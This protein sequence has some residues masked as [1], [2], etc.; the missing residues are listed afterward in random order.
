L[1]EQLKELTDRLVAAPQLD[2]SGSWIASKVTRPSLD[3][4]GSWVQGQITQ[5]IT[6]EGDSPQT[7]D[8]R[9]KERTF[10]PFA[11]YSTISSTTTSAIPSP[12]MST[13][14]LADISTPPYRTG[15]A[16]ALRPSSSNHVP[17][18]RASSAMD[19]V[20]RKASPVPRVSSAS[21]TSASFTDVQPTR[22][23]STSVLSNEATP[24]AHNI[25]PS[26]N[27]TNLDTQMESARGEASASPLTGAW[28]GASESGAPTPTASQFVPLGHAVPAS[29]DGFISLM[30]DP[31]FSMTPTAT[32]PSAIDRSSS[33]ESNEED[34]DDLGLGNSMKRKKHEANGHVGDGE[35]EIEAG[36]HD[37]T[38]SQ[39]P[40]KPAEK[41]AAS[42][43]WLSR[44]LG[45]NSNA[46]VKA[47]LGEQTS[48]Y[49]DKDLKRWVNKNAKPEDPKPSA[50]PPPPRAQT[51]SPGTASARLPTGPS[52]GPP[53]P[54]RP[55]T[56]IDLTDSPPRKPP[57]RVRSNL[58]PP[59]ASSAPTT[60]ASANMSPSMDGP[61][62]LNG[63]PPPGSRAGSRAKRNVR[64]RYVDVFQ[65]Q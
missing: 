53:P 10:G 27:L 20:R 51:A 50:P 7:D 19:Y 15:S 30:D 64:N 49:Y 41:P 26:A 55:A 28:W 42:G 33:L 63:P 23:F 21:A 43:S 45:R 62:G 31:S 14:D 46:P 5:I 48:F 59:E 44:I 25:A 58:V 1:V 4:F 12:Q 22:S 6:G 16:M 65:Q 18:N 60:P 61:P 52:P 17:I 57:I 32:R 35:K 56:A 11:H 34:E 36:A 37:K 29:S 13:I 54:I 38:P 39:E 24:R 9:V 3:K 40:E 8:V 2:K 47:S